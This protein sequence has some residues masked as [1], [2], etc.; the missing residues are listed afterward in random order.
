MNA[1]ASYRHNDNLK[2]DLRVDNFVQD[3]RIDTLLEQEEREDLLEQ[4]DEAVTGGVFGPM[5]GVIGVAIE[6]VERG[7]S[8]QTSMTYFL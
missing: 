4:I 2:F 1:F 7:L 6:G 8:S 5:G 3:Q